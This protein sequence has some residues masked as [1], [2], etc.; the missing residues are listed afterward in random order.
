MASF[1]AE[2]V[3]SF[4]N[5]VCKLPYAYND[6][7]SFCLTLLPQLGSQ[8][9]WRFLFLTFPQSRSLL[10]PVQRRLFW[11][12]LKRTSSNHLYEVFPP[13]FRHDPELRLL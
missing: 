5:L 6:L 1:L 13:Q 3:V 8:V 10:I 11:H 7:G 4:V 2:Q 12:I 9:L